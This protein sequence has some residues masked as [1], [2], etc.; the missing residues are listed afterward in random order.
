MT[1]RGLLYVIGGVDQENHNRL[2]TVQRYNPDTNLWQ[3]MPPLSAPRSSLCAVA[4]ESHLYAIGGSSGTNFRVAERFDPIAKAWSTIASTL[5]SRVGAGGAAVNQKVFVF[6]G[7]SGGAP[8][9]KACEMYDPATNTWS[10]ITSMVALQGFTSAVR[11]KGKIYVSG[12]FKE[13]ESRGNLV[14]Q[15]FDTVTSEWTA[16]SNPAL[17]RLERMKISSLRIP[18][19]V[20]DRCV[21]LS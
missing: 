13:G 1:F 7:L 11:F 9:S 15:V 2:N 6:G 17:A 4:D 18:R 14:L 20:L 21:V 3:G 16:C 10:A 8:A 12:E 5:E 19:V